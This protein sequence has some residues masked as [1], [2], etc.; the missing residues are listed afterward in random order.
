MFVADVRLSWHY[1]VGAWQRGPC[2][3]FHFGRSC[4]AREFNHSEG[5]LP[6]SSD[7]GVSLMWWLAGKWGSS[8]H[9]VA[10]LE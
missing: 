3:E 7:S 4:F 9:A 10:R 5:K 1:H 6:D 8:P 2:A